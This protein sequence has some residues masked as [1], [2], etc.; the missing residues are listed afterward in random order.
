MSTCLYSVNVSRFTVYEV[1]TAI[2]KD[3]LCCVSVSGD[4]DSEPAILS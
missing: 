4:C 1:S 3:A 2:A